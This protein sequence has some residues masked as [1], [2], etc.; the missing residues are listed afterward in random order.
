MS[1]EGAMEEERRLIA[2]ILERQQLNA[3][4]TDRDGRRDRTLSRSTTRGLSRSLSRSSSWDPDEHFMITSQDPSLRLM[5]DYGKSDSEKGDYDNE[6]VPG[7]DTHYGGDETSEEEQISDTD[8]EFSYDDDGS[9]L[10]NYSTYTALA[11]ASPPSSPGM[12]HV[13]LQRNSSSRDGS[14]DNI[15]GSRPSSSISP[16]RTS[17]N[18]GTSS[19]YSTTFGPRIHTKD[20]EIVHIHNRKL[21]KDAIQAEKLDEMLAAERAAANARA[22]GRDVS[23]DFMKQVEETAVEAGTQIHVDPENFYKN[24]P[25]RKEKLQE[26]AKYK[27]KLTSS[28]DPTDGFVIPYTN[29]IEEK[30]DSE[31]ARVL[32]ENI[33]ISAIETNSE[34]QRSVRTITRG[35]FFEILIGSGLKHPKSFIICLDFSEESK[36]ALEWCIGTVLVD[37]SVLYVL[38]VIEDDEYSSMQLNGIQPRGKRNSTANRSNSVKGRKKLS[39]KSRDRLREENVER[40]TK[41]ILSLLKLTKL[42]VHVVIQSSHHPI[43]RHFILCVIKHISPTLIVV[44]SKGASAMKGVLL[45]SL[46]N[47]LVRKSTAPV[48]VVKHKLKKLTK[49]GKQFNNNVGTLHSLAEARVD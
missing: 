43:P 8:N 10:P 21:I 9:V 34:T 18:R 11:A 16:V 25:K 14:S 48:M 40:I 30:I 39:Q 29:D 17:S 6:A 45:G 4:T 49:K 42:Q 24:N 28:P 27:K 22:I 19:L 3:M 23:T 20:E 41:D 13:S 46:S 35:N 5:P 12:K 1:L 2:Q 15:R 31:L 47:Y 36:N 38:N 7:A 44:G 33:K 26:Y 37:G 32:N